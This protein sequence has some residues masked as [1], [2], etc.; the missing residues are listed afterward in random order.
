MTMESRMPEDPSAEVC[1]GR[2][3]SASPSTYRRPTFLSGCQC[4]KAERMAGVMLQSP[5]RMMGKED[6]RVGVW[7][8]R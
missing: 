1:E 4:V 2:V 6:R 8:R 5:P 3:R 7:V